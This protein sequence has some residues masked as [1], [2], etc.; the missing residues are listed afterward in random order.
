MS[1][2]YLP[3]SDSRGGLRIPP[4][5]GDSCIRPFNLLKQS[6]SH[7]WQLHILGNRTFGEAAFL[8]IMASSTWIAN[9]RYL[10][11]EIKRIS[12]EDI[13]RPTIHINDQLHQCRQNLA[14][15]REDVAYTK[16]Y[17]PP[18]VIS[19]FDVIRKG[20]R[21]YR[22]LPDEAMHK[23][24]EEASVLDGFLMNTFQLLIS[25]ISLLDSETSI[26]Q[27]HSAK[28]L[29]WLAFVYIPLSFVTGIFGMNI[30]EINGASVQWWVCVT[31]LVIV[32]TFT[33]C[34]FGAYN[35]WD[36][37]H[38]NNIAGREKDRYGV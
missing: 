15:L 9:L 1:K 18:R 8:H 17:M 26:Q 24:L 27:A 7:E 37:R 10:D 35:L 2:L 13:R 19:A 36:K 11:S 22:N 28:K 5:F 34:I 29:T 23:L 4:L 33:L 3:V 21:S 38:K 6:F 32:V 20:E 31:V 30:K 16:D 12:F 14:T 25:S